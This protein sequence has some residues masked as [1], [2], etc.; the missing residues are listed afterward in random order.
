ME[1]LGEWIAVNNAQD[2]NAQMGFYPPRLDRYYTLKNV[3][4]EHVRADK[5]R[6]IGRARQV[7]LEISEPT[8]AFSADGDTAILQFQKD[9]D[10]QGG[11]GERRGSVL[12]E[13]RL[14][15]NTAGYWKIVSERDLRVMR[16]R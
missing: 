1:I 2:V 6:I 16:P 11:P 15:R 8:L 3:S 5:E 12:Q 10:I 4:R 14:R 7:T 9:Y 13:L